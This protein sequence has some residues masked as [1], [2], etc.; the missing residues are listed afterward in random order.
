MN[1]KKK[2]IITGAAGTIGTILRRGLSSEYEI[3]AIDKIAVPQ[4]E[5]IALDV[6]NY[7][8]LK[9][10]VK[11]HD[12]IIHLA[13]AYWGDIDH[14]A[15]LKVTEQNFQ[16]YTNVYRAA[17]ELN[18]PRVIMASSVH[19]DKDLFKKG[20]PS[21]LKVDRSKPASGGYGAQKQAI[22]SFGHAY[23]NRGLFD[24]ICLR[25]GAVRPNDKLVPKEE[26]I[27]LSHKDLVSAVKTVLEANIIPD[28][29]STFYVISNNPG[30]IQSVENPFGWE[31]Q[32]NASNVK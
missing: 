5:I 3:S 19:A 11:G 30:R 17:I 28:R 29:Y 24:V 18:I 13:W 12:V 14:D 4:E 7:D 10:A 16:M 31:P 8:Q 27:Y 23:A 2:I 6:S 21:S 1:N 15:M 32:D 9:E 22:E 20:E 26:S 25:F